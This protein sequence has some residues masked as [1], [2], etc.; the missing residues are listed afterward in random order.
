MVQIMLEKSVSQ[1]PGKE[2]YFC[3]IFLISSYGIT[4][5]SFKVIIQKMSHCHLI[6][7]E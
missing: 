3:S 1:I 4:F 2:F 5:S 6:C 7:G